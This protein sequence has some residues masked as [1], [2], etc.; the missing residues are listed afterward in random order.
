M[1][2]RVVFVLSMRCIRLKQFPI[3]RDN[4]HAEFFDC[5][6]DCISRLSEAVGLGIDPLLVNNSRNNGNQPLALPLLYTAM[7]YSRREVCQN[8]FTV[9]AEFARVQ[10]P[11]PSLIPVI[12]E[13][14]QCIIRVLY[15]EHVH[16]MRTNE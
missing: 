2:L 16:E 5:C 7:R 11:S 10:L 14:V 1:C 8:S 12:P 13:Y 9:V 3:R 15:P 4:I 6:S